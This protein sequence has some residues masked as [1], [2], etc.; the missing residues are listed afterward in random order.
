MVVLARESRNGDSLFVPRQLIQPTRGPRIEQNKLTGS[1]PANF[2]TFSNLRILHLSN[3]FFT[4]E[5]PVEWDGMDNLAAT[6]TSGY[7]V[8]PDVPLG[9]AYS[10]RLQ[11]HHALVMLH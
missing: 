2:A 7:G 10:V 5:I 9:D 3:N 6:G 8:I 1:P 4:D 11:Q